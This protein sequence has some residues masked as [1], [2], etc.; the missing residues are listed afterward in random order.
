MGKVALCRNIGKFVEHAEQLVW[1]HNIA[2]VEA[3]GNNGSALSIV[4]APG[5]TCSA[6]LGIAV[7]VSP[8]MMKIQYDSAAT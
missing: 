7:Y 2:F 6:V 3:A 8:V 1:K 4:G 5:G